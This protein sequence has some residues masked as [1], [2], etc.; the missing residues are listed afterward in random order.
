MSENIR[1]HPISYELGPGTNDLN[2][3]GL[4]EIAALEFPEPHDHP[5]R[6][7]RRDHL[8][9]S[10]Y[11]L[12][13]LMGVGRSPESIVWVVSVVGTELST[14]TLVFENRNIYR[15]KLLSDAY[16][17]WLAEFRVEEVSRFENP[18][19]SVPTH[20]FRQ[21]GCSTERN[22]VEHFGG[23]FY[24]GERINDQE[25]SEQ[26]SSELHAWLR[27]A[28]PR[29]WHGQDDRPLKESFIA[30]AERNASGAN[31]SIDGEQLAN[32]YRR[33]LHDR[34]QE[35]RDGATEEDLARFAEVAGFDLPS[36]LKAV[37]RIA[38]GCWLGAAYCQMMSAAAIVEAWAEQNRAFEGSTLAYLTTGSTRTDRRTLDIDS[39]P[40]WIPLADHKN[41]AYVGIDLLPGVEGAVGQV[42]QYDLGES[43]LGAVV[44]ANDLLHFFQQ[45]LDAPIVNI[46]LFGTGELDEEEEEEIEWV[47]DSW[48][49]LK[50]HEQMTT[51]S[52]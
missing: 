29:D 19:L 10:G 11:V 52:A 25:R 48:I 32:T 4:T 16:D 40:R 28:S 6:D 30:E 27:G 47:E 44:I 2:D 15:V 39:T 17:N 35:D 46:D 36:E 23:I 21:A 51:R 3:V 20:G 43:G 26:F 50:V 9:F 34:G 42:I 49:T 18:D 24:N 5:G 45:E 22:R 41:G 37:L 14:H 38:D 1:W 7:G 31:V 12:E 33:L 13:A 8:A